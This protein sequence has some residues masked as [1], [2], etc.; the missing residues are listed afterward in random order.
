MTSDL[1]FEKVFLEGYPDVRDAYRKGI[2]RAGCPV[3]AHH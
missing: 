3:S 1:G 2:L